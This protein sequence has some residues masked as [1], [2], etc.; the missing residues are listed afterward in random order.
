MSDKTHAKT[1]QDIKKEINSILKIIYVADMKK[2]G[3]KTYLEK[4]SGLIFNWMK[5]K[6]AQS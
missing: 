3:L 5:P 2:G 6:L 4:Q 1:K